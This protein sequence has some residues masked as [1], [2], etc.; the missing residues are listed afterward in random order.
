M[1]SLCL[2]EVKNSERNVALLT[3]M[4]YID[5]LTHSL[6]TEQNG[7]VVTLYACIREE[8]SSNLCHETVSDRPLFVQEHLETVP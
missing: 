1:K 5:W 2:S 4:G 6:T 8:P 7:V 3:E